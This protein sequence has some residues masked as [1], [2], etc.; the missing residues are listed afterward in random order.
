MEF[1]INGR[2]KHQKKDNL[3]EDLYLKCDM[4]GGF[5]VF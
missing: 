2:L 4:S 1:Y 3:V 5:G